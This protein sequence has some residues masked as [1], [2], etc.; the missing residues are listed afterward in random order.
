VTDVIFEAK[1][2]FDREIMPKTRA[3]I[4]ELIAETDK[5]FQK[6]SRIAYL[7]DCMTDTLSEAWEFLDRYDDDKRR[8]K[9][10]EML[11]DGEKVIKLIKEVV[12]LQGKI[13]SLR[14]S[15]KGRPDMTEDIRKA[16]EYP[17]TELIELNTNNVTRCPF[18]EDRNPS[19]RY[20]PESNTVYCFS[21]HRSWD[22]I[23]FVMERDGMT[24]SETV[25]K[26][27]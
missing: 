24:F 20:Y 25:R 6:Q 8:E 9:M 5:D 12:K 15:D 21:C 16:K 26:L 2:D 1:E 4:K 13:I 17:L 7:K 11:L 18:H 27:C 10:L 14:H 23:A 19:M 22:T 3:A